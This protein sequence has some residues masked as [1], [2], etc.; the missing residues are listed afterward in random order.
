MGS[1]SIRTPSN[2]DDEFK[3]LLKRNMMRLIHERNGQDSLESFYRKE[4]IQDAI[5]T[6]RVSIDTKNKLQKLMKPQESYEEVINRIMESN[7]QLREET[8]FLKSIE[9]ENRHLIKY[10]ES[11]FMREHK[12]LMYHPD[13]K[14]EYSYNESKA[15]SYDEFSFHLE[16][17]NFLLQGKPISEE[18]GIRTIQTIEI[19][20]SLKNMNLNSDPK[21]IIRKKELMLESDE[22][23]IR[24]KYVIYFKILFFIIN[25]KLDKKIDETNYL[26][27]DFWKDLYDTKNLSKT[28]FNEDVVQELKKYELELEQKKINTERRLWNISL[29]E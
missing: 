18:R 1:I 7:E 4:S 24:T 11:K 2:S 6:I 21:E 27:L 25:K 13:L 16:I 12:A 29:K 17:D 8:A 22:E 5:T 14:I 10:I 28:S 15:K 20:K 3:E 26:N 19:L 9:N 23:F